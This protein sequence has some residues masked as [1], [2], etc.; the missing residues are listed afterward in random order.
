MVH[1]DSKVQAHSGFKSHFSSIHVCD[2]EFLKNRMNGTM[3]QGTKFSGPG[4]ALGR[5]LDSIPAQANPEVWGLLNMFGHLLLALCD[6]G[7]VLSLLV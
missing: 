2:P 4:Q 7:V 1:R 5:V 6:K 3:A